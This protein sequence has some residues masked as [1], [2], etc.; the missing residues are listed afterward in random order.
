MVFRARQMSTDVNAGW[1]RRR[2]A[3]SKILFSCRSAFR[4][5]RSLQ[6]TRLS[7]NKIEVS[8]F[9]PDY[10][11]F[12]TRPTYGTASRRLPPTVHTGQLPVLVIPAKA[13]RCAQDI[14]G[15]QNQIQNA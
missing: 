5:R 6:E 3:A 15:I 8:R 12:G 4:S 14:T 11:R 10:I 9:S 7:V 13:L 1:G 2:E